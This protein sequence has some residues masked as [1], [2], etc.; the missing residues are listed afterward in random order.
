MVAKMPEDRYQ[1]TSQ[2][3]ADLEACRACGFDCEPGGVASHQH[4]S[5]P[6]ALSEPSHATEVE[7][8]MT[9]AL[10]NQLL[11]SLPDSRVAPREDTFSSSVND[12]TQRGRKEQK[13]ANM[14]GKGPPWKN[15]LVLGGA[16]AAGLL[17]VLLGVWVIVRD[18]DGKEVAKVEVP[19]GARS[20]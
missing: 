17:L 14:G 10:G 19:E 5:C 2:L 8:G 11:R 18:K 13:T 6:I 1:T 12:R 16:G 4:V 9:A 15:P 20:K 7:D 3:V